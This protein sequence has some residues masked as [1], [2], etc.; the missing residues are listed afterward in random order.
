M[1]LI[2][3]I[4]FATHIGHLPR[5]QQDAL[6]VRDRVIQALVV[7]PTVEDVQAEDC[8]IAVA[9]GVTLGPAGE[10]A[11]RTLLEILA[12]LWRARGKGELRPL[13]ARD[14]RTAQFRLCE[15]LAGHSR[16]RG[17]A[18]TLVMA[19]LLDD[20]VHILHVGDSRAYRITAAGDLCCLTKDHT[21]ARRLIEEGEI[22]DCDVE[23]LGSIMRSLDGALIADYAADD[24]PVDV[25]TVRLTVG[26]GLLLCTDGVIDALPGT[27]GDWWGQDKVTDHALRLVQQIMDGVSG[28]DNATL[29]VLLPSG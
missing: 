19:H 8:L 4:A 26:E 17:A 9:D 24:F 14:I 27:V 23:K 1:T 3:Q 22:P 29:V 2:H 16:T 11:S 28:E 25:S 18:T 10:I 6:V 13:S 21:A 20:G 5:K 12:D 7:Q 15:R